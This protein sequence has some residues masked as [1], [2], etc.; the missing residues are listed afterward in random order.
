MSGW[1]Q[2]NPLIATLAL[3]AAGL[4]VVLAIEVG[5]G[6]RDV[7]GVPAKR[8]MAAE[9]K[10]LPP[11]PQVAPE[12]AYAETT[13]RPIFVPTRRPAPPLAVATAPAFQRGQFTLQ[14]V[15]V[16]G[17]SRTAM[18]REKTSGRIHRVETGREINGVKVVQ[19]DPQ[20]VTLGM[21]EE[22][23]VVPLVV[24]RPGAPGAVPPAAMAAPGP[25]AAPSGTSPARPPGMPSAPPP[26]GQALSAGGPAFPT[27]P[28]QPIPGQTTAGAPAA[29]AAPGVV[30][31]AAPMSPEELLARRRA[32]R[33]QQNQ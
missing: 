16:A 4:L 26:G 22:R 8:G 32:R 17:G 29:A 19:I 15:I 20:A 10:L 13:T 31:P 28:G 12:Q 1:L 21:G 33:A 5:V 14:G 7:S 27:A 2:R 24:Q 3:L 11:L 25:F 23:E 18:L 9:A 30:Q 6:A